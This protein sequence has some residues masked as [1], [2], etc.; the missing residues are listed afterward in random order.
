[1]RKDSHSQT[2]GTTP[3][4]HQKYPEKQRKYKNNFNLQKKS[5]KKHRNNTTVVNVFPHPK[6][7]VW[8]RLLTDKN[9]L[10]L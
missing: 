5:M 4:N 7:V 2:V 10:K 8:K 3:G 1:M 6:S 9:L